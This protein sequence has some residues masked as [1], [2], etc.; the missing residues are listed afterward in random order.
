MGRRKGK[1][2]ST[3]GLPADQTLPFW[4]DFICDSF[5]ELSCETSSLDGEFFGE[6]ET[7][8]LSEIQFSKVRARSQHVTR[9]KTRI[10]KSDDDHFLISLQLAGTG[11]IRQGG[12]SAVLGPGDLAI[13]DVTRPYDILFEDSFEQLVL[14]IPRAKLT[15]RM[16]DIED[17]TA[18]SISGTKGVGKVASLLIQQTAHELPYLEGG[19]FNIAQTSTLDLFLSALSAHCGSQLG[20]RS[21]CKELTL[22]RLINHVEQNFHDPNLNSASLAKIS[23]LSERYIRKL[24]SQRGCGVSE[25]I[26]TRR[27]DN[28]KSDLEN[29]LLSHRSISSIAYASGF[30]DAS[31]FSKAFKNYF[32]TTPREQRKL[33]SHLNHGT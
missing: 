16:I 15:S 28:A 8:F 13:Y 18:I 9:E 25:W 24:F 2:M 3:R 5:V 33:S 10:A 30:R 27:L 29:P 26:W 31:H 7:A 20:K 4:R 12:N 1:I 14:K 22:R 23:G 19:E 17:H 32:G 21:E 11:Q 6:I